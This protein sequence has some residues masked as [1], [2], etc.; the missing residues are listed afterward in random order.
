MRS[1]EDSST[2][3]RGKFDGNC[4]PADRGRFR[5]CSAPADLGLSLG[6]RPLAAR[7]PVLTTRGPATRPVWALLSIIGRDLQKD[8]NTVL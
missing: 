6:C 3:A 1:L 5:G 4:A 7:D 2:V 8:A